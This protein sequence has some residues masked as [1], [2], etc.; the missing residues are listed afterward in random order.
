MLEHRPPYFNCDQ[1]SLAD[2]WMSFENPLT[3]DGQCCLSR[4]TE[5][6]S[7]LRCTATQARFSESLRCCRCNS[8]PCFKANCPESLCFLFS[9]AVKGR[10]GLRSPKGESPP[11]LLQA[12]NLPSD[13]G[14]LGDDGILEAS[15]DC[16]E[17]PSTSRPLCRDRLCIALRLLLI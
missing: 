7:M 4:C 8:S 2:K 9:S 3:D 10:R 16:G 6:I 5:L 1:E 13:A 12:D 11:E 14:R 17:E 15:R